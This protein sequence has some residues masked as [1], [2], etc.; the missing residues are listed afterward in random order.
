MMTHSFD[1]IA[2]SINSRGR[3]VDDMVIGACERGQAAA[4]LA[5]FSFARS[6]LGGFY[7][8]ERTELAL[9]L[10]PLLRRILAVDTT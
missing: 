5:S 6:R 10:S 3:I 7:S 2:L 9:V 8:G 1:P 4:S